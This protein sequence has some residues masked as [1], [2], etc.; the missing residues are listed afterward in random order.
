MKLRISGLRISALA[1]CAAYQ[2]QTNAYAQ[3]APIEQHL[4]QGPKEEA[5]AE[6]LIRQRVENYAK[7]VRTKNI[8][9]VMSPPVPVAGCALDGFIPKNCW[10]PLQRQ[11]R[12]RVRLMA[13]F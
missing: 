8:E 2:P 1:L 4:P 13:I 9:A 11:V 12:S 7:A 3:R 6:A 10:G 5:V